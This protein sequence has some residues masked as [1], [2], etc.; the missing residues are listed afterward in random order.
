MENKRKL[1]LFK[2]VGMCA[3]ELQLQLL[4]SLLFIT[5]WKLNPQSSNLTLASSLAFFFFFFFFFRVMLRVSSFSLFL[6]CHI[7]VALFFPERACRFFSRCNLAFLWPFFELV[8]E[9][10]ETETEQVFLWFRAVTV[11]VCV[12]ELLLSR[13]AR[14]FE[15]RFGFFW[16]VFVFYW[17]NLRNKI[18]RER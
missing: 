3:N 14:I 12:C 1:T 9:E 5:V 15:V 10:L 18:G 17:E 16:G 13:K 2:F 6:W 7:W 11:S 4:L 8:W